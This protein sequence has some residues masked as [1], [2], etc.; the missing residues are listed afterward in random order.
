[1]EKYKKMHIWIG[2][3]DI[4][5]NEYLHYFQ[6]DYSTEGD[7]ED[8]EYKL[9]QFCKD[10]GTKWYDE[11]FIGIIP[12]LKKS[13]P[14]IEILKEIPINQNEIEKVIS[15]CTEMELSIVNAVFYYI[16]SELILQKP[17]KNNYNN[18]KYIGLFDS[19]LQ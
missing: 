11:D 17:Y 3:S 5:E 14:I 13:V 2:N 12:V 8:T 15:V 1:M 16:D 9:C 7:F 18:L 10:I 6:L 4:P 19:Y